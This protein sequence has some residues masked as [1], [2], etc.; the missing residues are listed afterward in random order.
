SLRSSGK[1]NVQAAAASMNGGG[2]F[3]ASG[4]TF[5]GPLPAAVEAVHAAL[6]AQGL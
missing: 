1:I 3:M 4:L 6:R 2:H 5:D